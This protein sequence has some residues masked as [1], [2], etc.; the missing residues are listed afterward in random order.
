M[1]SSL[2]PNILGYSIIFVP[3][4]LCRPDCDTHDPFKRQDFPISLAHAPPGSQI[5]EIEQY[6][7]SRSPRSFCKSTILSVRPSTAV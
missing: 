7:A 4:N 5:L 2:S 1:P 6:R 3:G